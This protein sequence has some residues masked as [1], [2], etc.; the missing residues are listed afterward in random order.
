M[1]TSFIIACKVCCLGIVYWIS[2]RLVEGSNLRGYLKDTMY[3]VKIIKMSVISYHAVWFEF[4]F[5]QKCYLRYFSLIWYTKLII[6]EREGINKLMI[7]NVIELL[8]QE[9]LNI[10]DESQ[11]LL[12][13]I[14]EVLEDWTTVFNIQLYNRNVFSVLYLKFC[15]CSI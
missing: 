11:L 10:S 12:H 6:N 15:C 9:K 7:V 4:C 5:M 14:W 1:F 8:P 13:V 3:G 2:Y